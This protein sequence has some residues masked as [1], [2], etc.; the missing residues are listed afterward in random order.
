MDIMRLYADRIT[1]KIPVANMPKD[2]ILPN[3]CTTLNTS[4]A[5]VPV[6]SL[7]IGFFLGMK[8]GARTEISLSFL[9]FLAN[10][11]HIYTFF[12]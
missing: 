10:F 8:S 1:M 7:K 11:F 3:I 12:N 2:K 5:S 9:S 4:R 6:V